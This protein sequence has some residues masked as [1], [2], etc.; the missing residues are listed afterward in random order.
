MTALEQWRWE[1]ANG[2]RD[3]LLFDKLWR[4]ACREA[5]DRDLAELSDRRVS[6]RRRDG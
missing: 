2:I 5:S 4:R 1:L 3:R 6:D